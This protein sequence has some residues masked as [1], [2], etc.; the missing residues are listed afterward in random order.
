MLRE[1]VTHGHHGHRAADRLGLAPPRRGKVGARQRTTVRQGTLH[2][3]D[4][5]RLRG[6][7][8]RDGADPGAGEAR[9]PRRQPRRLRLRR[10][11]QSRIRARLPRA[12]GVRLRP[13]LLRVGPDQPRHVRHLALRVRGAEGEVAPGDGGGKGGRMLRP[14]R[15]GARQR[16]RR[17][18]DPRRPH[19]GGLVDLR[20]Q[21]LDYQRADRPPRRRLGEGP[22]WRRRVHR[23]A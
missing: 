22:R 5:R 18:G 11:G 6:G 23:R 4:R 14:H 9:A 1:R 15:A 2:A 21:A 17:D 8:I 3:A 7:A 19:A 12:G 13:A 20:P 16:S 10:H